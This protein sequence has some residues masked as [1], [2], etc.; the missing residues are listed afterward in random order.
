[1]NH[2]RF[3][4]SFH[5][6]LTFKIRGTCFNNFSQALTAVIS[7]LITP[8]VLQETPE[9]HVLSANDGAP[10]GGTGLPRILSMGMELWRM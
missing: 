8:K 7:E 3:T 2:V 10:H 5:L 6:S 4:L 1:V 9:G